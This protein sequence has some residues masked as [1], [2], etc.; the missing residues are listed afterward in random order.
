MRAPGIGEADGASASS[1]WLTATQTVVGRHGKSLARARV[2]FTLRPENEAFRASRKQLFWMTAGLAGATG[3]LLALLA[4]RYVVGPLSHLAQAATALADGDLSAR[5]DIR[6][7]DEIG[8]LARAFNV[9][10]SAVAFRE[11]RLHKE[12]ELA[13]HIQ[14]SILPRALDVPGL[15]MTA[16]MIPASKVGG[17]YYDVLPVDGGCWIGIGDV[18]GHGLDAGLMMLMTQSIVASLV[19][20]DPATSPREI[21]CLLNEVLYDNIRKRLR[22]DDHA[23]L[24]ILHYDRSGSIV[25]AGAHE[26]IVVY[27]AKDR[28]CEIV[29]T[30]GAWV[31]GRRDIREG[32]V[33]SHLQLRAGDVM[34]LH[35]DGAVEI[36]NDQG[37]EFGIER[38]C[39]A[40][41]SQHD[42]PV[43]EIREHLVLTIGSWGTAE[44]DVTLL[45]SRFTG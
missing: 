22:R 2:I 34:L 33:E 30:P 28:R 36:R 37:E 17:D 45:V 3:I 14:T 9:M 6:T 26:D 31:G 44:D 35:T 23:T 41:E 25:F 18:A 20:R 7:D 16:T 21:V 24:T 19:A 29:P 38:L 15:E 40:V 1:D 13:Q 12:V 27:R 42:R 10:S 8:D 32:T 43:D 11:E 39:A 5:V 4:R